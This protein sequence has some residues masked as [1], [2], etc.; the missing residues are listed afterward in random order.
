MPTTLQVMCAEIIGYI[1]LGDE[2]NMVS[3]HICNIF[4]LFLVVKILT[5]HL[6]AFHFNDSGLLKSSYSKIP[7][8]IDIVP[9]IGV[10]SL[11][12]KVY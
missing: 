10:K 4:L 6:I 7:I 2:M 12:N 9:R 1:T 8:S 3:K 11:S 5:Y